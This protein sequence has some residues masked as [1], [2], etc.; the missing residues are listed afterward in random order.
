M[1]ALRS[2]SSRYA[3]LSNSIFVAPN[4][5]N[6]I[7]IKFHST[8][9][10]NDADFYDILGIEKNAKNSDIKPAFLKKSKLLHPDINKDDPN[11]HDKFVQLNEAYQILGNRSSR[12]QYD[13]EQSL[14]KDTSYTRNRENY[15]RYSKSSP[16]NYNKESFDSYKD[17]R[18]WEADIKYAEEIHRKYGK[19]DPHRSKQSLASANM[20]T[21]YSCILI[22][23][24]GSY[25]FY[26][27]LMYFRSRYLIHIQGVNTAA[28][29]L[30]NESRKNA[31]E[32]G[33]DGQIRIL[34]QQMENDSKR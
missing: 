8:K 7:S 18:A 27:T 9:E 25:I 20:T 16:V 10:V 24:L 33:N 34:M 30:L 17:D 32:R 26:L 28:N 29:S 12:K 15:D 23:G 19:N 14:G 2:L 22:T 5:I 13:I 11:N 21:F 6:L 31:R 3:S 1:L 4:L